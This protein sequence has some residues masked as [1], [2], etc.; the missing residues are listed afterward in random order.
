MQKP[1]P[2]SPP[3]FLFLFLRNR[4]LS[5]SLGPWLI[6]IPLVRQKTPSFLLP[7]G[8]LPPFVR[9]FVRGF[10]N[11]PTRRNGRANMHGVKT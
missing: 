8:F 11:E 4:N 3:K 10:V 9:S 1:F 7:I 6:C 2:F 5:S